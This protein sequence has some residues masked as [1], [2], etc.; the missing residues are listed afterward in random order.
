MK[1]ENTLTVPLPPADALPVLLD[2][3]F[4]APCLPGTDLTREVDARTFEGKVS[5]KVGPIALSFNGTATVEEI[6]PETL[7]VLVSARGRE[8]RGRG[9]AVASVV[10]TLSPEGSGTKVSVVTDVTLAGAIIQY[11][12]GA[13][14]VTRTAQELVDQ[15]AKRLAARIEGGEAPDPEAIRVG[16]LLWKSI[17]AK[18]TGGGAA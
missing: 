10:F 6:D 17:K 14:I 12:R 9:S 2:I 18:V 7:T 11:A 16:S 4:V 15:F 13:G 8:D 1:I 3:P 5:L